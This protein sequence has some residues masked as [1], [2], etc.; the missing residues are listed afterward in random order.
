M[1]LT[2]K[3]DSDTQ[4]VI[5]VDLAG[6][7][8]EE[9]IPRKRLLWIMASLCVISFLAAF[10][11]I[12][13][14]S[15]LPLVA[16]EFNAFGLYSW[17]NTS[18]LLTAST[19]QP[20]YAKGADRVG[21]RTC[22]L[23]ATGCYL[24]GT[25]LCGAAQSMVMLIVA[26]ALCGLGIGAFDSLMKIV[27]ADYVPVRYIG[28]YQSLLGISW[29]LGYI[30]GA[31]LGGYAATESGWRTVF[32]MALG[33]SVIALV[34]IF[35]S[36]QGHTHTGALTQELAQ[37]D[38]GGMGLWIAGI[39]CLVLALSWGGTTYAWNSSVVLSLLCVS[40]VLLVVFCAWEYKWAADPIIPHT[41]FTNRSTVLILIAAFAYGGC[42]QSLMT[43]IPLYLSVIRKE[44]SMATNLELLCLVLLACIFNVLT[45]FVIVKT[46]RYTWATRLSLAILVLACGLLQFLSKDSSRGLIVGLM[47]VTGIGSG[48]MI[49]SEII[50]AQASV[51]VEHVP[52]MVAFMT[53]CDQVGGITGIAAQGSI[54][55]NRLAY[56]L[57]ILDLP[58]V[59]APLVRQSSDYLWSLPLPT[60]DIV[61]EAYMEA[62]RMSFWGSTSFAAAGLLAALG[63]QAYVMRT[64]IHT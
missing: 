30:V 25:V 64:Q 42:F 18:F 9:P 38:I 35:F 12:I 14:A 54:L 37:L 13:V 34:L 6:S 28:L 8:K 33:I 60:R 63:L 39:V 36:I 16:S 4:T 32:W 48:G 11:N 23:F 58:G 45:G 10:D 61:R 59:S 15:N 17:V 50:T 27:V 51:A 46:G 24:I 41:I 53:L 43:Y 56:N 20:L 21:R 7:T 3:V 31:L 44:D 19:S 52:V 26:R 47:I 49:N 29:G 5:D 2:E 22:L 62:V 57:H 1:E 55:S 40:G